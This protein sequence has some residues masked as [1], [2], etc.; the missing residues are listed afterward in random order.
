MDQQLHAVH[1]GG[2]SVVT[3]RSQGL[4]FGLEPEQ[5]NGPLDVADDH[6]V[7][8]AGGVG[9]VRV[10]VHECQSRQ[11]LTVELPDEN[12]KSVFYVFIQFN[13]LIKVHIQGCHS[14]SDQKPAWVIIN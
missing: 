6:E 2:L 14:L 12:L 9:D 7:V 8:E 13:V 10:G 5:W 3:D 11:R 1:F 4:P